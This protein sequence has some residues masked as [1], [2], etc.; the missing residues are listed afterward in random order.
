MQNIDQVFLYMKEEIER[1]AHL[2][3]KSILDEVKSMEDEAYESMKAEAKKDADLKLKQEE[4]EMNS[5]ASAEISESHIERTKKLIEKREEYV[6][7]IFNDARQ[8]LL[9]FSK[10]EDYSTFMVEKVKKVAAQMKDS[11]SVIYVKA[12]DLS[13][14]DSLVKAFGADV[15]VKSSDSIVIG[16]LIIENKESS[17]VMNETLD[18]ALDNQKEWFNKNSGLII[19]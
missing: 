9:D 16:G 10:S 1:Q 11:H 15:Q 4:E 5:N 8:K 2:E 19:R 12:D 14:K 17:L 6:K 18:F 7:S 3:E 13:L